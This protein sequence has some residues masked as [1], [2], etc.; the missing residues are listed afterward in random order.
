MR[1]YV[2][3]PLVEQSELY[4]VVVMNG[5]SIARSWQSYQPERGV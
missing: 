4:D 1:D 3:V 5:S 2:D